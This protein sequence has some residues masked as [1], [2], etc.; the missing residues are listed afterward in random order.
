MRRSI[1]ALWLAALGMTLAVTIAACGSDSDSGDSGDKSGP[2]VV[3]TTPPKSGCGSYDL[4]D[5]KDASGLLDA[6]PKDVQATYDGYPY[7]VQKSAWADWKP[8]GGPPYDI[9]VQYPQVNN[10]FTEKSSR[11]IVEQLRKQ[12]DI[13][14]VK[15]QSTGDTLDVAQQ[16]QQFQSLVRSKPDIIITLELQ[17]DAFTK[18]IEDAAKAGI[19]VIVLFDSIPSKSAVNVAYNTV[20]VPARVGSSVA[21]LAGGKGNAMMVHALPGTAPD[22]NAFKGFDAVL[23]NCPDIKQAG[24][25]YGNFV[26]NAAKSEAL[27]FL[28]S[29]PEKIDVVFETAGMTSG[30]ISA[31]ESLGRPMPAFGDVSA[32]K[33]SLAYW[34][35]NIDDYKAAGAILPVQSLANAVTQITM[36]MLAGDGVKMTEILGKFPL[37]TNDNLDQYVEDDW[38]KSTPGDPEGGPDDFLS[39]AEVDQFFNKAETQSSK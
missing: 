8:K 26:P 32:S 37:V 1:R 31:F 6:L 7:E 39:P 12:P 19:P 10:D 5:P 20:E 3:S 17:T 33:A 28:A 35:D 25:I 24:S 29:H 22:V 9:G 18:P 16:L 34:R 21:R 15:F 30:V 38:T 27:K 13:G 2:Q 36:K 23:K 4:P 14:N 11:F